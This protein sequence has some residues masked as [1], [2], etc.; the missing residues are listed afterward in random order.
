MLKEE[1][2]NI[3][4]KLVDFLV[5]DNVNLQ[6]EM[7]HIK[8][9]GIVTEV[10]RLL[11]QAKSFVEELKDMDRDSI[12][13]RT[14]EIAEVIVNDRR[15]KNIISQGQVDSI[16]KVLREKEALVTIVDVADDIAEGVA[17]AVLE[18]LDDNEDG[19]VTSTEVSDNCT[20]CGNK[21]LAKCWSKFYKLFMLW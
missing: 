13:R 7:T 14:A 16:L 3:V 19:K 18:T 9:I 15:V 11:N 5:K 17:D 20:C 4:N 6:T 21:K 8:I 10:N 12:V 2:D 1:I